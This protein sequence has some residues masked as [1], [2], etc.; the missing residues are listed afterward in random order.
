MTKNTQKQI[1]KLA[2]KQSVKTR[3]A[4]LSKDEVSKQMQQVRLTPLAKRNQ[5][6]PAEQEEV[7]KMV[8]ET[9]A[10]LRRIT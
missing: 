1:N 9:V 6:T 3:F 5:L 8:D 7:Q 4:G 2:S 10:S